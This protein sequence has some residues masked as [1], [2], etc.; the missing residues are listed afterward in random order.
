MVNSCLVSPILNNLTIILQNWVNL[1][2]ILKTVHCHLKVATGI[3]CREEE[4][5]LQCQSN[6]QENY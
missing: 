1:R 2:R 5:Q 3:L 4:L 6:I